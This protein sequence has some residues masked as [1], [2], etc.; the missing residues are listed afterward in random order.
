MKNLLR[1][2]IAG[3]GCLG[4]GAKGWASAEAEAFDA[5]EQAHWHDGSQSW[6][7]SSLG[8]GLSLEKDGYGWISRLDGDGRVISARWVDGLDAPTGMDSLGDRLWVADRDVL[9]EI[10]VS[11]ARVVRRVPLPDAAFPNDVAAG[12]GGEVYVSDFMG[13]R[14]FRIRDG[15]EPEIFVEG[16]LLRYPNGLVVDGDRLVV[17]TWGEMSDPATFAVSV[18]GT[19]L[20]IDLATR[21]LAP[22]GDGRPMGSFD[23]IVIV[24]DLVY[25]T[26]WLGGRLLRIEP[27]GSFRVVLSGFKQLADLGYRPDTR[28][29][30]MPEMSADRVILMSLDP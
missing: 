14:I 5:P 4:F 17:A 1:I 11:E 25:G 28:Q 23:G 15:G 27:D 21:E 3:L 22:Y 9:V 19:L 29:L 2:A 18:P 10:A 12:P 8:G 24:G 6:F 30:M 16:G 13:H 26:D 20:Q 7:V